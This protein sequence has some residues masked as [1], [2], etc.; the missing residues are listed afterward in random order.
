MVHTRKG[1][2]LKRFGDQDVQRDR[3][4]G[5]SQRVAVGS[6]VARQLSLLVVALVTVVSATGVWRSG[7]YED[8]ASVEAM[9]RGYDVITLVVVAP[10]LAATLVARWHRRP[11][12]QLL[13]V[14]M[15]TYCLYN[16]AYYVFG[17]QLN[18]GFL[19][20]VAI[21]AASLYA[22]VVTLIQLD[23]DDL[24]SR[25]GRGTPGRT[26]AVILMLLAVGLAAIQVSGALRFAVTG[27]ALEE[28]SR[29]VVPATM[30]QLGAALDLWLLVPA[31]G[32]AAVWLWRRQAWG[33]V[34][35]TMMLVSGTLH[36]ASYVA[37][38][39]FQA[40]AEIPGAAF[41]PVEPVIVLLYL[42]A[43]VLLL[44]RVDRNRSPAPTVPARGAD[45][46]DVAPVGE[47]DAAHPR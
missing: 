11:L 1:D 42:T 41:D 7:L 21:L 34:L 23:V 16:Y 33:Y 39:V 24:A 28:P 30:T 26:V 32:L 18:A 35:A 4:R 22:L 31:Y 12:A 20:H 45:V 44:W 36:Q 14:S 2:T 37:G 10:L 29:L 8:A 6:Y 19:G 17:A 47:H 38:M 13:R 27:T 5:P 3:T 15:L 40:R 9:F 43:A 25:F 46:S